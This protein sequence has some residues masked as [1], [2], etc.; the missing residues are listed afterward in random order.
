M[1]SSSSVRSSQGK[2]SFRAPSHRFSCQNIEIE[3]TLTDADGINYIISQLLLNAANW[4][5]INQGI[6][7]LQSIL[8]N[9]SDMS[10]VLPLL[11]KARQTRDVTHLLRAYTIECGF[12]KA[13]NKKLAERVTASDMSNPIS[14]LLNLF[15]PHQSSNQTSNNDW[16]M[17]FVG[18]IFDDIF[19]QNHPRYRFHGYTYRGA[20]ISRN[21][22]DKYIVGRLV[23]NKSFTSTSKKRDVA[24]GFLNLNANQKPDNKMPAIFIFHFSGR[25][26]NFTIDLKDISEFP[27]EEEVLVMPGIPF[28]IIKVKRGNQIEIEL[29]AFT[30]NH[31]L[32]KKTNT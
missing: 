21:E 7:K 20:R 27:N 11:E 4:T 15:L 3:W 2:K 28:K 23:F 31:L 12:Y 26:I 17:Y 14:S 24:E 18:P 1:A 6:A 9:H 8:N 22:L 25:D 29:E 10:R 30:I 5:S 32:G 16:P 19:S 13:L